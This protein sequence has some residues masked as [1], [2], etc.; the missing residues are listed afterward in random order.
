MGSSAHPAQVAASI[1]KY[2]RVLIVDGVVNPTGL[3]AG[4]TLGV[5]LTVPGDADFEWW[6]IAAFRTSNQLKVAIAESGSGRSFMYGTTQNP[7][8]QG[9][10]IDLLAGLVSNNA[11]FPIAVPYV[12]PASRTYQ[13]NFTDLSGAANTVELTYH[14][15]ALLHMPAGS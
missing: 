12:M 10:F 4:V 3:A 11:A 1:V 14:G 2:P 8:Q 13:H 9:L 5:P 15:F 6:W 7:S